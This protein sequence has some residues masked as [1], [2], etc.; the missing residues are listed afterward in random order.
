MCLVF[1]FRQMISLGGRLLFTWCRVFCAALFLCVCSAIFAQSVSNEA[2]LIEARMS[3]VFAKNRDS[4]VKVTVQKGLSEGDMTTCSG[5]LASRDGH[6]ITSAIATFNA[7][8]IW[9]EWKGVLLDAELVGLDPM[10]TLSVIK[11]KNGFSGKDAAFIKIE[12]QAKIPAIAS[13]LIVIS[14]EFGFPPSPR[15]GI[16]AGYDINF[17]DTFLP[18]VY[19]R[20]TIPS[21]RGSIGSPAFDLDGNFAGMLVLGLPESSGSFLMPAKALARIRDDII[22]CGEP[23]YGWFG[24]RAVDGDDSQKA[25]VKIDFVISESPADKAGFQVGDQI[26][27]VNGAAIE[28]NTQLRNVTFFVRPGET[29][30]FKILRG[31]ETLNLDLLVEKM[32]SEV[33][34]TST[35]K[36][37]A[38]SSTNGSKPADGIDTSSDAK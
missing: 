3:G 8:K 37:A 1:I 21:Y 7:S 16:V 28:N 19:L 17:G 23:V 38:Q 34:K 12:N 36:L 9:V 27:E 5:F 11:I 22:L 31:S 4:I 20:T 10:T 26:L 14:R 24:M 25:N 33:I 35:E 2:A 18:A 30:H 6:V 13:P 32:D 29:A 15:F